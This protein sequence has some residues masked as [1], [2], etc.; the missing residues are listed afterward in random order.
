MW[1]AQRDISWAKAI[2]FELLVRTLDLLPSAHNH[3]VVYGDNTGIMEGWWNGRHRN[4]KTNQVFRQIHS[5]LLEADHVHEVRTKYVPSSSNPADHPSRGIYNHRSLLL[6]RVPIPSQLIPFITDVE[7]LPP[8]QTSHDDEPIIP[9]KHRKNDFAKRIND[10]VER[11][12]QATR[13]ED[14]LIFETLHF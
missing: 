8:S 6:P 13:E 11:T 2:G 12:C 7:D 3:F 1:G 9:T 4:I 10:A 5:F 14:E